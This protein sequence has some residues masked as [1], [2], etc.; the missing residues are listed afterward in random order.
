MCIWLV[1]LEVI[2][3]IV[4]YLNGL[5]LRREVPEAGLEGTEFTKTLCG[6][7]LGGTSKMASQDRLCCA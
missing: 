2:V 4:L 7:M 5:T 1:A 3:H 6:C